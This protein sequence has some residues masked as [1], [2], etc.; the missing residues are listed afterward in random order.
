MNKQKEL[1]ILTENFKGKLDEFNIKE[2]ETYINQQELKLA[3]ET[4]CDFLG[5]Q[6]IAPSL[7]AY[8]E[9]IRLGKILNMDIYDS[10]FTYL[11][12]LMPY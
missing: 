5:D 7:L 12:T 9:I 11:K 8:S 4:L 1:H 3:L 10:R 6:G 2:I